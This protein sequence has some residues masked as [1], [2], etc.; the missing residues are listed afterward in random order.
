MS[1]QELAMAYAGPQGQV[2]VASSALQ[3]VLQVIATFPHPIA[4]LAWSAQGKLAVGAGTTVYL[5]EPEGS[6]SSSLRWRY[7]C[8]LE[9]GTEVAALAWSP[10]EEHMLAVCGEEVTLWNVD[11]TTREWSVRSGDAV[12]QCAFS[13]DGHYLATVAQYQ[14]LVKIWY[15]RDKNERRRRSIYLAHPRSILS[16]SW[17]PRVCRQRNVL[18]TVS[19][20]G[21]GRLWMQ[22]E[23]KPQGTGPK[24]DVRAVLDAPTSPGVDRSRAPPSAAPPTDTATVAGASEFGRYARRPLE[25]ADELDFLCGVSD[26]G[27]LTIWRLCSNSESS[28]HAPSVSLTMQLDM[29]LGAIGRRV[30]RVWAVCGMWGARGLPG[31][32]ECYVYGQK[33]GLA[34]RSFDVAGADSPNGDLR[35]T[36]RGSAGGLAHSAPIGQLALSPAPAAAGNGGQL[37]ASLDSAHVCHVWKLA[38]TTLAHTPLSFSY[39]ATLPAS[40]ETRCIAWLAGSS[41]KVVLASGAGGVTLYDVLEE[42]KRGADPTSPPSGCEARR[43]GVLE[44]SDQLGPLRQL[45][46]IASPRQA[47]REAGGSKTLYSRLS[48]IQPLDSG[49]PRITAS[50]VCTP[51]SALFNLV[52]GHEDGTIRFWRLQLAGIELASDQPLPA[53]AAGDAVTSVRCAGF[54]RLAATSASG[55]LT[56]WEAES[57]PSSRWRLDARLPSEGAGCRTVCEWLQVL[58][59]SA[60]LVVGR[61][62]STK[63]YHYTRARSM[64]SPFLLRWEELISLLPFTGGQPS[65]DSPAAA[66]TNPSPLSATSANHPVGAI[67]CAQSGVLL[68]AS[69][70]QIAVY[71]AHAPGGA[72]LLGAALAESCA[73]PAYHPHILFELMSTSRFRPAIRILHHLLRALRSLPATSSSSSGARGPLFVPDLP[74]A[75]LLPLVLASAG[76]EAVP[77]KSKA[78]A[79]ADA[80]SQLWSRPSDSSSDDDEAESSGGFGEVG[81]NGGG[82]EEGKWSEEEARELGEY[83]TGVRLGGVS[84]PEQMHL[85]AVAEALAKHATA[86]QDLDPCALRFVLG[87]RVKSFAKPPAPLGPSDWLWA[88]HSEAQD[89]LVAAN[90]PERA[91]WPHVRELG[92]ALW[93]RNPT[94]VRSITE[95]LAKVAFAGVRGDRREPMEAAIWY[96][97]L[98][99]KTALIALLKAEEWQLA[100]LKN[101]Y[102]LLGKRRYELAVTFFLLAGRDQLKAAL[103][104]CVK[105]LEDLHLARYPDALSALL[106]STRPAPATPSPLSSS[107]SSSSLS[108]GGSSSPAP[109]SP[110]STSSTPTPFSQPAGVQRAVPRRRRPGE[111]DDLS[112]SRSGAMEPTLHD[113]PDLPKAMEQGH[114]L[115]TPA[116]LQIYRLLRANPQLRQVPQSEEDE[117]RLIARALYSFLHSRATLHALP[118]ALAL[119][120]G[121]DDDDHHSPAA[122][123]PEML[124]QRKHLLLAAVAQLL[125]REVLVA[126]HSAHADSSPVPSHLQLQLTALSSTVSPKL[127]ASGTKAALAHMAAACAGRMARV[128]TQSLAV[129]LLPPQDAAPSLCRTLLAAAGRL[130]ELPA[131]SAIASVSVP[132]RQQLARAHIYA[133]EVFEGLEVFEEQQR[134]DR[135]T[136]VREEEEAPAADGGEEDMKW[137][138]EETAIRGCVVAGLLVA[139]WARGCYPA[140]E[141]LLPVATNPTALEDLAPALTAAFADD[142]A[143]AQKSENE[144]DKK[145][146]EDED[147]DDDE[148]NMDALQKMYAAEG[149]RVD[150]AAEA[151]LQ[152]FLWLAI[153]NAFRRGLRDWFDL[154]KATLR[155][156]TAAPV[157]E[158]LIETLGGWEADLQH[159]LRLRTT[160][161]TAGLIAAAAARR[162]PERRSSAAV[163]PSFTSGFPLV[164]AVSLLIKASRLHRIEP[165]LPALWESLLRQKGCA[166]HLESELA[167]VRGDAFKQQSQPPQRSGDGATRDRDLLVSFAVSPSGDHIALATV[168][169]LREVVLSPTD[170][171]LAPSASSSLYRDEDGD[172][173]LGLTDK[174]DGISSRASDTNGGSGAMAIPEASRTVLASKDRRNIIAP[175]VESHPTYPYY[176]SGGT[177]GAVLLWGYGGGGGGAKAS[178]SRGGP[179]GGGSRVTRVR[180]NAS[181]SKLGATDMAGALSLWRFDLSEEEHVGPFFKYRVHSKRA[182]ELCWINEG[183]VLATGGTSRAGGKRR[184]VALWDVLMPSPCV[185]SWATHP[186]GAHSLAY[187]PRHQLL[188]SGGK[189]GDLCVFDLRQRVLLRTISRAH[190]LNIKCLALA[191]DESLLASGSTDGA[192]RVWD[193]G[194]AAVLAE[195]EHWADVHE[196]RTFM[197]PTTGFF[198]RPISTYGAMDVAFAN[199]RLLSCGADGRLLSRPIFS[200]STRS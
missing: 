67:G 157:A 59:G 86:S 42:D 29:G 106:T 196:K 173:W 23:T 85:L 135:M 158:R 62:R 30:V 166:N 82:E 121:P 161:A 101:A 134:R 92:L 165:Q 93:A 153:V 51:L 17:R 34:F 147:E 88:L 3:R 47:P 19:R 35:I 16:I 89:T 154:Y 190:A 8:M 187:S 142:D 197:K 52:T 170:S 33:G 139:G 31:H 186:G 141:V 49:V 46:T 109:G 74:L 98:D 148:E 108:A 169:G 53:F 200:A 15:Q 126:P 133:L 180:F 44:G 56:I 25:T 1:W 9:Q 58:E 11:N 6:D 174:S 39:L 152:A 176:V 95:R 96:L 45:H 32:V 63:I 104:V 22:S 10:A 7:A 199:G 156:P 162:Q 131:L 79:E 81:R 13:P 87:Q 61:G 189:E 36:H 40:D 150:R 28:T 172:E 112:S 27:G 198:S 94:V 117:P 188:V 136:L 99:K 77:A 4:A 60:L 146:S 43:I 191:P 151:F 168:S 132:V 137:K 155:K 41:G 182:L 179:A 145:D 105:N 140:V 70:P 12:S 164:S 84:G 129:R 75:D 110:L 100:A 54:H 37:A 38:D 113:V 123:A 138:E 160:A 175:W 122:L 195:R 76:E 20:D 185:A 68:L 102:F 66:S 183:S 103:N 21:V 73:L 14:P 192:V 125:A 57:S 184:D 65:A 144:N 5:Y 193:L 91:T 124:F 48:G 69:G 128:S 26:T 171:R 143:K 97:A 120:P 115:G 116:L 83:L 80:Y 55:A 163:G 119:V 159:H 78:K 177:D 111:G 194:G 178:G 181:G 167:F 64:H 50:I 72:S 90:V 149:L 114:E 118:L 2:M 71:P 18:L 24:F 130:A 107:S 127:E